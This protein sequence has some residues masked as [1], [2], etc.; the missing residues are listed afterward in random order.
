M[1]TMLATKRKTRWA[2]RGGSRDID[3]G[4]MG[5]ALDKDLR[6]PVR[7]AAGARH[8]EYG[9]VLREDSHGCTNNACKKVLRSPIRPVAGARK[10][11]TKVG[12]VRSWE[13]AAGKSVHIYARV[14]GDDWSVPSVRRAEAQH[15]SPPTDNLHYD[16]R[17]WVRKLITR[18][19]AFAQSTVIFITAANS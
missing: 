4:K 3:R 19:R 6:F 10:L 13:N 7:P 11:Q 5:I 14:V 16:G 9:R 2:G 8:A 17:K 1:A 18:V 15:G 12:D